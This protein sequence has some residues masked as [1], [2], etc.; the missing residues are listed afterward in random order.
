M[1]FAHIIMIGWMEIFVIRR[2]EN[3]CI[4]M[5]NGRFKIII[6]YKKIEA[7]NTYS[8]LTTALNI[9]IRRWNCKELHFLKIIEIITH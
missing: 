2:M 7:F 5:K 4:F 8:C 3:Y 9:S 6:L 1:E